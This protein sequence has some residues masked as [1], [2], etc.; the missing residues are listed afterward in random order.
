[1]RSSGKITCLTALITE[2][3]TV[4]RFCFSMSKGYKLSF[5]AYIYIINITFVSLL[6]LLSLLIKTTFVISDRE[7]FLEHI[8][9][10]T[11][12]NIFS[13]IIKKY[14]YPKEQ[15]YLNVYIYFRNDP[16]DPSTFVILLSA[17]ISSS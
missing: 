10:V 3:K 6:S 11:K 14:T 1:M 15:R 9:H 17:P 4:E 16:R 7:T 2:Q 8:A 12:M 5:R 13:L